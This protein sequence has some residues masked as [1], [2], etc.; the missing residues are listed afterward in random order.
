MDNNVLIEKLIKYSNDDFIGLTELIDLMVLWFNIVEVMSKW[1]YSIAKFIFKTDAKY[2][3]YL[4]SNFNNAELTL[5][6]S[7]AKTQKYMTAIISLK[8]K[9]EYYLQAW[10]SRYVKS[11]E[12]V[13]TK[14]WYDDYRSSKKKIA[15]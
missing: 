7:W 11:Q 9:V 13:I 5:H 2:F 8:L 15:R 10:L 1:D 4:K 3:W 6:I 12:D 14:S